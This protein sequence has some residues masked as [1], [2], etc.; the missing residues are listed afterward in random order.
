MEKVSKGAETSTKKRKMLVPSEDIL[1]HKEARKHRVKQVVRP[2]SHEEVLKVA[3]SKKT[4][5]GAIGCAVTVVAGGE[6][7]LLPLLPAVDPILPPV[8]ELPGQ[9]NDP[10]CSRKRKDKE[11]A[12]SVSEKQLN[13]VVRSKNVGYTD[14]CLA[15]R[16]L[17]LD[18]LR[19][20]L[21]EDESDRDRMRKL[22]SYVSEALS[23]PYF[24]LCFFCNSD[25]LVMQVMTE[26]DDRLRD[27]ERC[28]A[29]LMES[30]KLVDDARRYKGLLTDALRVKDETHASLT[31]R[32]GE[33]LRLKKQLETT[34]L[35][36]SKI[37]EEVS[38]LKRSIPVER[39]AAVQE[40]LGSPAF[41]LAIKP[42]CT[43]E[44]HFEKRKWM[45]VLDRYDNGSV[46]QKYHKEINEYRQKGKTFVLEVD[47]SSDEESGDEASVD[48][49]TQRGED[50]LEDAE[51]GGG[52]QS[53]VVR[54]STSD[55]DDQ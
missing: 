5:V 10:S 38:E 47:P 18:E 17:T 4:E 8:M 48:E 36:V 34:I 29:Q 14:N 43:R 54:G 11:K 41:H 42:H 25:P 1:F 19:E 9:G 22:S 53:D 27:A 20:S 6:G 44:I 12:T 37:K 30:K 24:L 7:R 33:N 13:V 51:D 50:D 39:E 26:Y 49:Q 23:F 52:T 31:R 55:E 35:E 21:V 40:Y 3:A 46:L 15:K 16:R 45:A 28:K 32:N 2:K